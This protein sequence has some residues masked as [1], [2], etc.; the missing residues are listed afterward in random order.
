V[1]LPAINVC[2]IGKDI[3]QGLRSQVIR[4]SERHDAQLQL[5]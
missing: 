5:Q 1:A 3:S 2:V 4:Q